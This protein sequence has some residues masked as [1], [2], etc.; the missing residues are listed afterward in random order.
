MHNLF[1]FADRPSGV[2]TEDDTTATAKSGSDNGCLLP[3]RVVTFQVSNNGTL[4][5]LIG[6]SQAHGRYS[7]SYSTASVKSKIAPSH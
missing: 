3:D 2:A 4:S 6:A 7:Q 5:V 1:S